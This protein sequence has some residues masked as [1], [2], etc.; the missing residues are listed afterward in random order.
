MIPIY[1]ALYVLF[2]VANGALTDWDS[3]SKY[4]PARLVLFCLGVV[5]TILGVVSLSLNDKS[6]PPPDRSE[7]SESA[8]RSAV[9]AYES[10]SINTPLLQSG[11]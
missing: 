1:F 4:E 9:A 6:D 3:W 5:V 11:G 2:S 7:S 8:D 10:G